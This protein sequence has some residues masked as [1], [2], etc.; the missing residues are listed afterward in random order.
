MQNK[1]QYCL[2]IRDSTVVSANTLCIWSCLSCMLCTVGSYLYSEF[3]Y[4]YVDVLT[5]EKQEESDRHKKIGKSI[6]RDSQKK[7]RLMN[8]CIL[9]KDH[10]LAL[11]L[12]ICILLYTLMWIACDVYTPDF[13]IYTVHKDK[14]LKEAQLSLQC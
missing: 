13:S 3:S 12:T 7:S 14:H 2:Y 10:F 4:I 11:R 8:A 9:C 6:S 5:D 1:Q